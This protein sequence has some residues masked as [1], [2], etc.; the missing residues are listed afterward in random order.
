MFAKPLETEDSAGWYYSP[1]RLKESDLSARESQQEWQPVE[2]SKDIKSV[3]HSMMFFGGYVD[4]DSIDEI[5]SSHEV[6]LDDLLKRLM[7]TLLFKQVGDYFRPISS[8]LHMVTDSE[9]HNFISSSRERLDNWCER[10]GIE[11]VT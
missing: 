10:R 6:Q 7:N 4:L 1:I 8:L 3:I 2:I 5:A 11:K 9:D